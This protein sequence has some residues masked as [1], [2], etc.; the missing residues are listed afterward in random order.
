ML[1]IEMMHKIFENSFFLKMKL[2]WTMLKTLYI[3]ILQRNLVVMQTSARHVCKSKSNVE[4][5]VKKFF[6]RIYN[7]FAN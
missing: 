5:M 4:D 2:P 6:F 1:A 3:K 7:M